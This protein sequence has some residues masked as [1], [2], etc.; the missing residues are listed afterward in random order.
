MSKLESL[1]TVEYS[2]DDRKL[3]AVLRTERALESARMDARRLISPSLNVPPGN[4][5]KKTANND[6]M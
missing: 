1:K 6:T 5:T 4:A 3:T 2:L